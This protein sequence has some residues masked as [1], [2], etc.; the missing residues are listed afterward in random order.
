MLIKFFLMQIL[1]QHDECNACVFTGKYF[2]FC[3]TGKKKDSQMGDYSYIM[4][5][6]G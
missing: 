1:S 5:Y 3:L 2:I 6:G 4:A